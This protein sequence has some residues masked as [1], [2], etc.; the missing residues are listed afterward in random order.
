MAPPS[1]RRLQQLDQLEA[2]QPAPPRV[3]AAAAPHNQLAV[4]QAAQGLPSDRGGL[5]LAG[6][7]V[8]DHHLNQWV[9]QLHPVVA[10]A[11]AAV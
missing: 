8:A 5:Q 9:H 11:A 2:D 7:G 3:A 6:R 10:A 4:A 1:V